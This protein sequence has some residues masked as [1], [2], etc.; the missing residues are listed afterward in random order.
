MLYVF[1]PIRLPEEADSVKLKK[2][3][4]ELWAVKTDIALLAPL[5][6]KAWSTEY[7]CPM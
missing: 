4:L 1:D 2:L 5:K 6:P 3:S 7:L